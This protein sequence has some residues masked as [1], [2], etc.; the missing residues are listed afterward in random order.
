M[1]FDHDIFQLPADCVIN[2]YCVPF[3]SA[4]KLSDYST[5]PQQLESKSDYKIRLKDNR[6]QLYHLQHTLYADNRFS[7]LLIFQAMDA[8]GKD[9]TIRK[10]FKGVNPAG[11]QV[12]SFKQPSD[13]ELEHDFLWR[14]AKALPE[15]GRIGIF[16]RSYYEEVLVVRVNPHF[17]TS[18]HL[19]NITPS[20]SKS[21]IVEDSFWQ[22]RF[23]SINDHERH[24]ATNG[25]LV[26]KFF[27][28]VS[29]QEQH[30]RFLSRIHDPTKNWK[31]SKNDIE[32]S[33][34]WDSYQHAYQETLSHTSRP[35]APWY[36]IP[37]DN[38]PAMRTIVS[39][40]VLDNLKQLPI[41]YPQL[42]ARDQAALPAYKK[43]LSKG[44]HY[45]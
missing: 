33:K 19:S 12:H 10:V 40:I 29:Q 7:I 44:V 5:L 31:F 22:S 15:R 13:E 36:I 38:K 30:Q 1:S 17:L 11:F 35:W 24:L 25:T 14:T 32:Q 8:A 26:L 41:Q 3:Q 9:S 27:L 45:K 39:Q 42:S 23:Q 28:N 16:N 2:D 20:T 4:I 6:K 18:Q 37:A 43:Q 21:P 34:L